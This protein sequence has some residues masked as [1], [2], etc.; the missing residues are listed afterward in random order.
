MKPAG[1]ER[2]DARYSQSRAVLADG[3]RLLRAQTAHLRFQ[4]VNSFKQRNNQGDPVRVE[5]EKLMAARLAATHSPCC[6]S[7]VC[8]AFSMRP[9]SAGCGPPAEAR[10]LMMATGSSVDRN[11]ASPMGSS[12]G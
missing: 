4:F 3:P 7:L 5:F 6:A 8:D 11:S 12:P 1:C 2:R 10:F 9:I